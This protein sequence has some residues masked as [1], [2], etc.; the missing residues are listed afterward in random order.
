MV[1]LKEGN[2]D[3][4]QYKNALRYVYS[5]PEYFEFENKV[6]VKKA[7]IFGVSAEVIKKF[8]DDFIIWCNDRQVVGKE[9]LMPALKM[10]NIDPNVIEEA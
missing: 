3:K 4:D 6:F 7:Y 1:L 8:K 9:Y 5:R 2:T 10:L